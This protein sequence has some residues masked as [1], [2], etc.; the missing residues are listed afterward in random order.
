[1]KEE[2]ARKEALKK[3]DSLKAAL[4]RTTGKP[5]IRYVLGARLRKNVARLS[6]P[7]LAQGMSQLEKLP[8]LRNMQTWEP[9]GK[10]PRAL[11][12]SLC[13]HLL[14]KYPMPAFLWSG[15]FFRRVEQ[16]GNFRNIADDIALFVA[17]VAGGGSVYDGVKSGLLP[18]PLTRKMCHDLMQMPASLSFLE[19]L[20]WAVVKSCGGSHRLFEAWIRSQ[21][22]RELQTRD[23]EAF[24][25]TVVEWF[26]KNP[27]VDPAQI[28]PII[29]YLAFRRAGDLQFSIKGR[30]ILAVLRAA[31][32]WHNDLI[33]AR[34]DGGVAFTPSGFKSFELEKKGRTGNGE[35]I[36]EVW[37]IKEVLSQ[38]ALR[39]EGRELH[40][41]VYSYSSSIERGRTSI[42]SL[43][44]EESGSESKV[45]TL[46]VINATRRIVQARG[47]LNRLLQSK[48][49]DIARRW[50][51]ENGMEISTIL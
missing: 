51:Q 24:L 20:R 43:S 23:E 30:S 31:T 25:M 10:S 44:V 45:A 41:C 22:G 15:L 50:A 38:K 35:S 36:R 9:K 34:G 33:K 8:R 37:R 29:D 14:A 11:F 39:E 17:H 3:E 46:E 19:A 21:V 32:Q 18:V 13:N 40:H 48:E 5:D 7:S 26:A 12:R 1:M 2:K 27:M 42:W 6:D 28:G 49:L 4:T 16:P 47:L